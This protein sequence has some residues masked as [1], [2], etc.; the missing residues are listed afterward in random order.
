LDAKNVCCFWGPDIDLNEQGQPV[1][2]VFFS[3]LA[4]N[5]TDKI[6][7]Y[8]QNDGF[9]LFKDEPSKTKVLM[10]IYDFYEQNRAEVLLTKL[11]EIKFHLIVQVTPDLAMKRIFEKHKLA[12]HFGFLDRNKVEIDERP[13]KDKPLL[14]NLFGCMQKEDSLILSH[15]DLFNFFK[16]ALGDEVMPFELK[17]ALKG[18][19]D[20]IFLG[21]QFD[22]WYVQ[23]ILSMLGLHNENAKFIRYA[24]GQNQSEIVKTLCLK[25]FKFEFIGRDINGFV[26]TLHEKC[27]AENLLRQLDV[28]TQKQQVFADAREARIFDLKRLLEE[29]Y[30]LL[31]DYEHKRDTADDPKQIMRYED[32]IDAIREKIKGYELEVKQL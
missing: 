18:A 8:N 31:S 4:K 1:A 14:Y 22:K 9:F 2:D 7:A 13:T 20:F 23:M 27:K 24:F 16:I 17:N 15:S 25:H 21:F 30:K 5:N 3:N 29:Q 6:L 32:E 26:D 11:A 28:S 10:Q 19:L 12:H